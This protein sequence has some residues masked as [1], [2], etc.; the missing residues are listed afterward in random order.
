MVSPPII[1]SISF[2]LLQ[3]IRVLFQHHH[4]NRSFDIHNQTN[5]KGFPPPTHD[6]TSSNQC[7]Q[8]NSL[9]KHDR[10]GRRRHPANDVR[11]RSA[12]YVVCKCEKMTEV[13]VLRALHYS[14]SVDSQA[15]HKCASCETHYSH[16]AVGAI[17]CETNVENALVIVLVMCFWR[18]KRRNMAL[19]YQHRE[20]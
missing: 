17:I 9:G 20:L 4:L 3:S 19:P 2:E 13:E 7:R 8:R 16:T 18:C 10:A 14:L 5:I 15:V 12:R 1:L 11:T 6:V